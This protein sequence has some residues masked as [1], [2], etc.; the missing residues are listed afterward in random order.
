MRS[1][2][3]SSDVCSSDLIRYH[4]SYVRQDGTWRF[5]ERALAFL[6]YVRA[7]IEALGGPDQRVLPRAGS[8]AADWPEQLSSWKEFYGDICSRH[9]DTVQYTRDDRIWP[10]RALCVSRHSHPPVRIFVRVYR[11]ADAHPA[12]QNNATRLPARHY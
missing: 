9:V 4:D 10:Q 2:D 3:W 12:G 5:Q 1:S 11:P 6:Y 7:P 8:I